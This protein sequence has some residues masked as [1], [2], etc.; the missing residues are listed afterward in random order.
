IVAYHVEW[1]SGALVI[2]AVAVGLLLL[3]RWVRGAWIGVGEGVPL[4]Y[5][6]LYLC[7]AE[8]LPVLLVLKAYRHPITPL[9]NP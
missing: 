8:I 4:R 2:G 5:I 6:F 7:T 1:R 3:Y 9:L